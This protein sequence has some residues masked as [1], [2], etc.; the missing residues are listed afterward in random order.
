MPDCFFS[1][2]KKGMKSSVLVFHTHYALLKIYVKIASEFLFIYSII[3]V[4][5]EMFFVH[6]VLT[7]QCNWLLVPN[8]YVFVTTVIQCFWKGH[9]QT[10]LGTFYLCIEYNCGFILYGHSARFFVYIITRLC[11]TAFISKKISLFMMNNW[12][13]RLH[14]IHYV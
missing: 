2:K 11:C 6:H 12:R 9:Q 14:D 1:C 10:S 5:V 7:T 3:A 8:Q 4:T 13:S